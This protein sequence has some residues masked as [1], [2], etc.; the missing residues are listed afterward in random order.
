MY[1]CQDSNTRN[2]FSSG[3]ESYIEWLQAAG[4]FQFATRQCSRKEPLSALWPWIWFHNPP[5]NAYPKSLYV[6]TLSCE[7]WNG[8]NKA[9]FLKK[10]LYYQQVLDRR[11]SVRITRRSIDPLDFNFTIG[12]N[13]FS[14]QQSLAKIW[15]LRHQHCKFIFSSVLPVRGTT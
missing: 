5:G 2:K 13:F 15:R 4:N 8:E 6:F 12:I 11:R 9:I 14:L 10:S 3:K 1:H 7:S